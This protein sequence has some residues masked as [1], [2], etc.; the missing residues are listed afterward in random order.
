MTVDAAIAAV[1]RRL[2]ARRDEAGLSLAELARRSGVARATLTALEAGDGNPT[3]ETL[4][5]L[6]NALGLPLSDLI[7]DPG[8][9]PVQVVRAGEGPVLRGE[10]VEGRL[11]ERFELPSHVGEV[12]ALT[13]HPGAEQI[14]GA[15]PRGVRERLLVTKGRAR[16][17]PADAP[18]ELAA[19]DFAVYAAD[20][21]HVFA[22]VGRAAAEATLLTISP[23]A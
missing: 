16:V 18:V 22:A 6:A 19:G 7:G 15:H 20:Q 14:S 12:F 9:A 13:L 17:G 8:P 23:R 5:A 4:Y 3:L 21:P 11:I 10:V 2:R 1:G